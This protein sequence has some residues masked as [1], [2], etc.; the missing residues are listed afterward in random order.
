[1]ALT[2]P[3]PLERLGAALCH[4]QYALPLRAPCPC[5]VTVHDLSF[6]RAPEL[7]GWKDRSSSAA[8]S[9]ARCVAPHASLT[10]SERTRHDLVE[11]Y[12]VSPAEHRRDPERRRPGL[13]AAG[14]GRESCRRDYVLAVGADPGAARTSSRRSRRRARPGSRSSSR[15]LRRTRRSPPSSAGGERGSRDTSTSSG[16]QSSTAERPVSCR[17]LASRASACP[18]SRRWPRDDRSSPSPSP[19]SARW[20]ETRRVFVPER[21]LA[22]GIRRAIAERDRLVA[23][24]LERARASAGAQPPSGRSPC[25]WRYSAREGLCR[26]RLARPRGRAARARS[27]RSCPRSTRRSSSPTS[28]ARPATSPRACASSRTR[29]RSRSRRT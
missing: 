19:H 28:P 12:G 24:G 9:P 20:P 1:M 5:V 4:T 6:A 17:R 27:R 2:L 15:G 29:G 23:A 13:P 26:R 14:A 8:S 25:T 3:R 11:L 10:V 21:G 18:C 16:S 22:D 7:M